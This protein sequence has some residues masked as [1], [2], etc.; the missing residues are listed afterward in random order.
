MKF[1]PLRL[2]PTPGLQSL[3]LAYLALACFGVLFAVI[4]VLRL[5]GSALLK[6]WL[7]LYECWVLASGAAGGAIALRLALPLLGTASLRRTLF[8]MVVV[9]FVAP[10]IAGSLALPLYGTMFG[11]FALA[12]ILAASPALAL[13]WIV[14]LLAVDRLVRIWC[15]ERDSIF[16]MVLPDSL[17]AMPL[18][19]RPPA[20]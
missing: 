10:I 3:A 1:P 9:T 15:D 13:L 7:T 2:L 11:P 16:R 4:V 18:T 14:T 5:D 8:G 12:L 6:R 20:M 17:L 19:P